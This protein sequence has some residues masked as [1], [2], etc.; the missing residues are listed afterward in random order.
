MKLETGRLARRWCGAALGVW[1]AVLTAGCGGGGGGGGTEVVPEKT[2]SVGLQYSTS[3]QVE[4]FV[5]PAVGFPITGLEGHAPSCTLEAGSTVPQGVSLGPDCQF[6]G[7]SASAGT[8]A[9]S[10]KLTVPGFKGEVTAKYGFTVVA[11]QLQRGDAANPVVL[12]LGAAL[13]GSLAT[14][15]VARLLYYNDHRAGDQTALSVTEGRLPA[16]LTLSADDTGHVLAKG[17]ATELG[18]W[19]FKLSF[20]LKRAGQ[21][22]TTTLP[23]AFQVDVQP[24]TLSYFGCCEAYTG[25][26]MSFKP[27]TNYV[28]AAGTAIQF[29]TQN[30]SLPAGLQLD[31]AT[32]EI[33][34]TPSTGE[35]SNLGVTVTAT[36]TLDGKLLTQT[37]SSVFISPV[38]V[39]G[40]YPVSSQGG[41]AFYDSGANPPYSVAHHVTEGQP[42][43]IAPGT[44]VGGRPGDS[45]RF[46]LVPNRNYGTPVPN[47]ISIDPITGVISG[48]K[49][50]PNEFPTFEVE[51]TLNRGVG[52]YKVNQY[53][54]I[55]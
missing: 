14:S 37:D 39:F 15:Q 20:T 3:A 27:K 51:V 55:R 31:P 52:V 50:G 12:G 2:L 8:F 16:G 22:V 46:R 7:L 23:M 35:Q 10:V 38:G 19:D 54:G 53:W 13:D 4:L 24:L 17:A 1:C 21:A 48:T 42:F 49:P 40:S 30:G 29:R 6:Q 41:A 36:V 18:R 45:Y 9:G 32:G 26:P 43:S 44:M 33:S 28:A 34:G 5:T 25:V 11:P 47:W